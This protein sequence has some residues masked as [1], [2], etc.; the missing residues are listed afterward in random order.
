MDLLIAK[1]ALG[2]F[3]IGLGV[4]AVASPKRVSKFFGLDFEDEAMSAFG[5]REIASGAGLLSPVRPGPWFWMRVGGDVMDMTAL[6]RAVD[7]TNPRRNYAF[8][9]LAV[10]AGIAIL[11][12]VMAAQATLSRRDNEEAAA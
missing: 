4:I 8:A 2:L 3:S 10:V 11:D 7:R 1:R 9:A 6:A 5:A 12:L